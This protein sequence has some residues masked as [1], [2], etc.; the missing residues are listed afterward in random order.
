MLIAASSLE[1][2]LYEKPWPIV[3]GLVVVWALMRLV[4]VRVLGG[5]REALGRRLRVA[6]WG[7]LVV[8]ALVYA[9]AWYVQTPRE[10]L[11]LTMHALLGA[12]EQEDWAAFDRLTA[13]DATG[14]Y[15]RQ[16]YTRAQID[17][18]LQAISI[19][20]ITLL[21][22]VVAEG[23]AQRGWITT[24]R[25]RVRAE[26]AWEGLEGLA[27]LDIAVWAITWEE[28]EDGR[29]VATRFEHAGS[30]L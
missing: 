11:V 25:L 16:A 26:G 19:E 4:G 2:V 30:G 3:I 12:V 23:S 20:D 7:V 29:W 5:E 13:D 27:G 14:Q 24:V 10:R 17:E 18:T 6:S 1:V 15:L 8:A 22:G 21:S 9:L 28:L